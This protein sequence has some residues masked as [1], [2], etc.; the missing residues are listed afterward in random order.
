MSTEINQVI[1]SLK[2][3]IN[4]GLTHW[5]ALIAIM[6]SF[7]VAINIIYTN[8]LFSYFS[9]SPWEFYES[10]D[11][12]IGAFMR[13]NLVFASITI[14]LVGF[15]I[16]LILVYTDKD[17]RYLPS[18]TGLIAVAAI[19]FPI[20]VTSSAAEE[21]FFN[22][23]Y[24]KENLLEVQL[25]NGEKIESVKLIASPGKFH[26]YYKQDTQKI[27]LILESEIVKVIKIDKLTI[28]SREYE[29]NFS[30]RLIGTKMNKDRG[31]FLVDKNNYP[32]LH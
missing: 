3:I 29:N 20:I 22:I 25:K 26:I 7:S 30:L 1:S 18:I 9:I 14:F 24:M 31:D 2:S 19:T 13:S 8:A 23:V 16:V 28:S 11:I 32:R 6:Y 4:F 5:I 10:H 27:E 17:K 12:L 15:L 21:Q